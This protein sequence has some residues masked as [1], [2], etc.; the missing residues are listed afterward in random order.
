[1]VRSNARGFALSTTLLAVIILVPIALAA[2]TLTGIEDRASERSTD[3]ARSLHKADGACRVAAERLACLDEGERPATPV[4]YDV[5]GESALVEPAGAD[6][7]TVTSAS[8]GGRDLATVRA[9]LRWDGASWTL[10]GYEKSNGTL[11]GN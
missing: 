6:T 3:L 10:M 5:D 4:R 2:L 7:W 8:G 9:T 1:M 11:E